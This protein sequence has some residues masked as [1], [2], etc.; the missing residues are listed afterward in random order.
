[1]S[2]ESFRSPESETLFKHLE[3]VNIEKQG[4]LFEK[5]IPGA[6]RDTAVLQSL[7]KEAIVFRVGR[8]WKWLSVSPPTQLDRVRLTSDVLDSFTNVSRTGTFAG[9]IG[10]AFT[11]S[12]ILFYSNHP[13]FNCDAHLVVGFESEFTGCLRH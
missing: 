7:I 13:E 3:R 1:M 12:I 9:D 4:Q 10:G 5:N 6:K 8:G 11:A 2:T